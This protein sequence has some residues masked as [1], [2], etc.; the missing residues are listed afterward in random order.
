VTDSNGFP[1]QIG[2]LDALTEAECRELLATRTFGR[3]GTTSGGLPV[4]LPVRYRYVDGVITFRT[5]AGNELRSAETGDVLAFQVDAYDGETGAGWSVLALG[6]ATVSTA[7]SQTDGVP[8]LDPGHAGDPLGH[9]LRLRG[10]IVTGRRFSIGQRGRSVWH[11]A[12]GH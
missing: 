11:S 4:I 2:V 7:A 3:V 9:D 8:T 6:R 10:E 12:P 5:G 1:P